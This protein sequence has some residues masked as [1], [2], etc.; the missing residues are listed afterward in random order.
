M[1]VYNPANYRIRASASKHLRKW[2]YDKEL[3]ARQVASYNLQIR[4]R[5]DQDY[6]LKIYDSLHK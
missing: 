1:R 6:R 5:I 2:P 4:F 3:T